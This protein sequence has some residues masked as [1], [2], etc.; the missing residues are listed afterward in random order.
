MKKK[1]NYN[2]KPNNSRNQDNKRPTDSRGQEEIRQ[3]SRK[4]EGDLDKGRVP[5]LTNDWRYYAISE[6]LAKSVGNIPFNL[7]PGR[8]LSINAQGTVEGKTWSDGTMNVLPSVMQISYIPSIGYS[9]TGNAAINVAAKRLYTFVR[10][11]NSGAKVYEAPD[12]MMYIIAMENCY[13][14]WWEARRAYQVCTTYEADNRNLPVVLGGA[15]GLDVI[16]SAGDLAQANF[17]LNELRNKINSF[18][19]PNIFNSFKR[20]SVITNGVFMDSNS[21]RGQFYVY[22]MSYYYRFSGRTSETGSQLIATET[23]SATTLLAKIGLVRDAIDALIVDD[24]INTMSGDMMKAFKDS[25]RFSLPEVPSIDKLQIAF[26]EDI[27]AQIENS[28]SI[29]IVTTAVSLNITQANANIVFKPIARASA[30]LGIFE[31]LMWGSNKLF[32][33]HVNNPDFKQVLEWTRDICCTAA[34][35]KPIFGA[36]IITEYNIWYNEAGSVTGTNIDSYLAENTTDSGIKGCLLSNFDWHPIIYYAR[37]T[38]NSYEGVGYYADVK[39]YTQISPEVVNRMH[40]CAIQALY[41]AS[42]LPF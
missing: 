41:Y 38:G 6:Q 27:L 28:C 17:E 37:V 15:L 29:S 21:M 26:D 19:V 16:S 12:L 9:D 11:A 33:S 39:Y 31:Q 5:M 22:T 20:A 35:G 8:P 25:E 18:W 23:G 3:T 32:N 40:D 24:D 42:T 4:P 30:N 34:S 2:K 7:L 13:R 10:H 36:E 1:P 14:L